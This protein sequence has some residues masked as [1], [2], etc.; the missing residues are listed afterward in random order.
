MGG[1]SVGITLPYTW[2]KYHNVKVGDTVEVITND[3]KAII[4][5]MHKQNCPHEDG[6][7]K[8]T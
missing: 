3:D 8:K 5:L 4:K 7:E 6:G 1:T 2:L